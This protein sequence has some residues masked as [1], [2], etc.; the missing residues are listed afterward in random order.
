MICKGAVEGGCAGPGDALILG[1]GKTG[2]SDG[3]TRQGAVSATR[4]AGGLWVKEK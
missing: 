2:R 4:Y 1:N 3:S